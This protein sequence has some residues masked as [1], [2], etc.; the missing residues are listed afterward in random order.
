[1]NATHTVLSASVTTAAR[2]LHA[3]SIAAKRENHLATIAYAYGNG[4][5]AR[6]MEAG[7]RVDAIWEQ[8]LALHEITADQW[9]RTPEAG[10]RQLWG[11]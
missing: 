8:L 4:T 10:R 9:L 3:A 11:Y 6:R 5:N 2:A 7:R 1:M